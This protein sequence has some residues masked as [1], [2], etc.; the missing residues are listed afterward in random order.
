MVSL[1]IPDCFLQICS[2]LIADPDLSETQRKDISRWCSYLSSDC[3]QKK[4]FSQ[5]LKTILTAQ[6]SDSTN[7]EIHFL[8]PIAYIFNNQYDRAEIIINEYKNKPLTGIDNFKT[9]KEVY[10]YVID[11][12]EDRAITHPDLAKAKALL[13]K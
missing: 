4:E 13:N 1:R 2:K 7:K 6:L 5:S 3:I 12:L 10:R 11:L 9:Y 8:L